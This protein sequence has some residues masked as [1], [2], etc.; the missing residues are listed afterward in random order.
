VADPPKLFG[1]GCDMYYIYLLK[2]I[3]TNKRYVG[4]TSREV[5]LRLKE[6][7]SGTKF[8][9]INNKPFILL[10][11]EKFSSLKQAKTREK[12]LKTSQGRRLLDR[13]IPP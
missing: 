13:I 7:N 2:S 5:S 12:F 1:G 6:H 8:W 3:K 9:D 4:F 10:Y 11:T